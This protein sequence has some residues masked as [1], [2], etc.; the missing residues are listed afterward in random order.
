M[1]PVGRWRESAESLIDKGL[2]A[3]N[4]HVGDPTGFFNLRITKAGKVQAEQ[5]DSDF[6]NQLRTMLDINNQI[7]HAQNQ[8]RA[9]AEQ[10]AVQLVDLVEV[11][12]K[13][14]GD[15]KVKALREWSKMILTRALEMMR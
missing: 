9:S 7:K 1:M 14:T 15:D 3:P 6:D 12:V 8:A 11:A 13:V 10:I 5:E 4:P 2:I